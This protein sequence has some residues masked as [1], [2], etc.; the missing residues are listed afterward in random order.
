MMTLFPLTEEPMTQNLMGDQLDRNVRQKVSA[1]VLSHM[2]YLL[3]VCLQL[4][5]KWGETLFCSL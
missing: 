3:E 1:G 2:L 4:D 5:Q